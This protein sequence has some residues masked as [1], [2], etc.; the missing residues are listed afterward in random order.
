MKTLECSTAISFKNI[1]F[2]TDFTPASETAFSCALAFA[3]YFE[4][5]LYPAHAVTAFVPT[6]LDVP[7]MPDILQ[8]MEEDIR[9]KLTA[10]VKNQG[11][12]STILVTLQDIEAAAP[13]WINEHG[14]DL[15]VMGTHGRKGVDRMF[16]GSTAESIVR[17]ATCPVLT[18]GP[19]VTPQISG[20]LEIRKV[21]FAT[22]LSKKTE[23]AASYAASFAREREADLTVLHALQTP[24]EAREIDAMKELVPL[25][26]SGYGKTEFFVEAGDAATIILK[27]ANELRSELIVMGLSEKTKTSTHF[28]RGVAYKVISSAP[29]AVLTVR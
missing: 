8:K 1:L 2:L 9:A 11:V 25:N 20:G 26:D 17:T 16:L 23:P 15:I 27:Y 13:Q 14:I 5:R 28:R 24:A 19:G 4:A 7:V 3:R 22:S 12:S 21:L 29:C 18:V 6:E 10:L